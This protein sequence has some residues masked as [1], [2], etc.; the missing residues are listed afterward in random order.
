MVVDRI[1]LKEIILEQREL[2]S[3]KEQGVE[4]EWLA[5]IDKY[6]KLPQAV[7]ITGIRRAGKSTLLK[8]IINKYYQD[9][10]YFLNFE[11]ERLIDF[12]ASDFNSL[13]ELFMEIYGERKV[14]FLDEIQNVEKWELFVRRMYD[15][16]YKFFITGSNASLLSREIGNR[17]TGRYL[18]V[19]L[20]PFSF[21]EFLSFKGQKVSPQSF[22]VTSQRSRVKKSFNEYLKWGGMP[23]YLKYKNIDLLKGVYDDIL[24]RD[25]VARY[26][27]KDV[28]ALRELALFFMSNRGSL[29][30]YNKLKQF[31]G[32]G[33]VNT[34]K[35]Y[36]GYLE[37]SFL[38][39]VVNQFS[40]SLKKQSISAKKAYAVDNGMLQAVSFQFSENRGKY[41]ENLVYVE[42]KR[43]GLEIYYYKTSGG[44][45]VDFIVK[46]GRRITELIQV[47]RSLNSEKVRKREIRALKEA[48]RELKIK[49]AL[50]LTEDGE[51]IMKVDGI[52]IEVKPIYKWLLAKGG[53]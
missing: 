24:Y 17:L 41:L 15:R 43:R 11:D 27:I 2:L 47:V 26:D 9:R 16:G 46:N 6:V 21:G 14:F 49:K 33:S 5:A 23:E 38:L 44:F 8:Q 37:N 40:Y 13:L 12:K 30:T 3:Q 28:K 10:C 45:E 50:I 29:F 7:V 48:G 53:F 32:L 36:T 19:H 18:P 25:I 20:F 39:F 35:S 34:A 22:S 1:L 42:L 52:K 51:D 31:L 4:R